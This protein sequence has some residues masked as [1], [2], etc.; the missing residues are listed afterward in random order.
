MRTPSRAPEAEPEIAV[1]GLLC[2]SCA[3]TN[4]AGELAKQGKVFDC[5]S[6]PLNRIDAGA[7]GCGVQPV[8]GSDANVG[9]AGIPKFSRERPT[10]EGSFIG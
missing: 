7:R 5:P 1:Y 3:D 10:N 8:E 4:W 9:E 2:A 6:E